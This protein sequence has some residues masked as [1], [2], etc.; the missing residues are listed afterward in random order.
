MEG[1]THRSEIYAILMASLNAKQ[2]EEYTFVICA[3]PANGTIWFV[4]VIDVGVILLIVGC[5]IFNIIALVVKRSM[6]FSLSL[7]TLGGK[8]HDLLF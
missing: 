5:A 4:Y 3:S 1:K 6:S 7:F 2:M 8:K